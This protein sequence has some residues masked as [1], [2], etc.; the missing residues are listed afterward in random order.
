MRGRPAAC[1]SIRA[2]SAAAKR[3]FIVSTSPASTRISADTM[4]LTGWSGRLPSH[5]E[6]AAGAAS[7]PLEEDPADQLHLQFAGM[8]AQP[9]RD[10]LPAIVV[11]MD[12]FGAEAKP[13][14]RVP[15]P[16]SGEGVTVFARSPA[17]GRIVQLGGKQIDPAGRAELPEIISGKEIG[18][19]EF[20]GGDKGVEGLDRRGPGHRLPEQDDIAEIGFHAEAGEF[21]APA[22]IAAGMRGGIGAV[23]VIEGGEAAKLVLARRGAGIPAG[24]AVELLER[25]FAQRQ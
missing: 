2:I 18:R 3:I 24:T 10:P 9:C 16:G 4:R 1:R 17:A 7:S 15:A 19:L 14:H 23:I 20:S 13:A 21:R 25:L 5:P 8:R 22:E 11:D 6:R 12:Q